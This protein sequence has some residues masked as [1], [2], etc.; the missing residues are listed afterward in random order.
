M[1]TADR[2]VSDAKF[3]ALFDAAMTA[4]NAALNAAVPTPMV[5]SQHAN[6]LDDNSPP[7]KSWFVSEGA[8]GFAW[9]T[10]FPGTSAAARYAKK[11][12]G[13]KPAYG[14]GTQYWVSAGGQSIARKEAFAHAF[15][16]VLRD[17][18]VTAYAGSRLD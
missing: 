12:L 16:T 10:I 8:C 6:P 14:G 18:G 13:W 9:V 15:A 17:G 4:G 11:H 7:V 3:A 1:T 2:R 5:V